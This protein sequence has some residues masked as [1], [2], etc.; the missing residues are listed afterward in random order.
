MR[1]T[2]TRRGGLRLAL[3]ALP[4]LIGGVLG[5]AS[6][7]V[8]AHEQVTVEYFF[9]APQ[10]VPV[11]IEGQVY[12]RL[13]MTGCPNSGAI[14]HPALPARGAHIL[15]PYGTRVQ[16]IEIETGEA[17]PL[18]G[19]YLVEPVGRPYRLSEGPGSVAPPTPDPAVYGLETAVPS[20]AFEPAGTHGFRGYDIAILKLQPVQYVPATGELAYFPKLTVTV[21]TVPD[22][23]A[24]ALCR[25]LEAD[26]RE[27]MRKV[28]N[29]RVV[30][31]YFTNGRT[32]G[33]GFDLLVITTSSL[34]PSF[35][36]LKDYHDAH[37]IATEI[38]TT[39]DVGSNDP[40]EVRD[41]IR[42]HYLNDGIEYVIIGGDDDVIPA[43]D[44]YVDGE[45]NMPGDIFFA[46]LDGTWNG[47]GDGYW[48][49]PNDG[50]GGG[51]VDLVADVYV[52]RASVG[53][54]TEADRFVNKTIWYLENNHTTTENV[55]LVGEYLGFGGVAEYAG[56]Y[57]DQLIDGSS[58]DGYTTVGIPS[59]RYSIDTLYERDESWSKWDLI[60]RL[61]A[62]IHMLNHL[63]HGSPDYAMHLYNSDILNY[64][65]NSDLCFVYSQTC[66]AGHFDGTDCWAEH[67]N[68]KIDE[69]AYAVI[70]NA[71]Y[72]YGASN[73]TD[74]P[75]HRYNR[76]LW[77]AV[78]N[79]D[80]AYTRIGPANHDSKE[81][82]IYRIN[83]SCMRWCCYELNLFG[84]PTVEFIGAA[85]ALTI[86]LPEELPE[87]VDPGAPVVIPVEIESRA[88]QYVEGSGAL[89]YRFDGGSYQSA[90][91]VHVEGDLYEATLPGAGC[92]DV[93]EYYFS[94]EGDGGTTVCSPFDAP[95]NV[96]TAR[97]GHLVTVMEDDFETDQGWTVYAGADTGNWER[98]DP[99]QVSS[100][101]TITQPG[102]DHT[103][104]GTLCFVTGPLAGGGAGDYDVDGGP[105]HL[106]S[107]RLE[108]AGVDAEISYWRWY[109]I[110]TQWND[111]LLVQVSNDDGA[112]WTTVESITDR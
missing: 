76:E 25:G 23:R 42:E 102:D 12:D 32:G 20:S 56:N 105:T 6:P 93:P 41:Y 38:H 21:N 79:Q 33:K 59:D 40:V 96:Y 110:S 26:Q 104:D 95:Q 31:T 87:F 63:G 2:S 37:G 112:T 22:G 109:H 106:T 50:D 80:E 78:F 64:V 54:A 29:P 8:A 86:R 58:A 67:M 4:V 30:G 47:D 111:E 18:P 55:Q 85:P 3:T 89:H 99:Q 14:G 97:V 66:S 24:G 74:G 73:S 34:K 39:A 19:R 68:I 43:K 61:D 45:Y 48:G 70:M 44:L 13:I 9:P 5:A 72:G 84:D 46:C 7:A 98:A 27:A 17:V 49:E 10:T 71:R 60:D 82:N 53:N 90:A 35:Q 11:V 1:L 57:L 94:A 69:G 75:S 62:G 16:D 36:P 101:G 65:E 51:D 107:P 83:D 28:D 81:D 108:L 100:S 88:E 91:L 103:P 77:D 52:G 92:D 15:L